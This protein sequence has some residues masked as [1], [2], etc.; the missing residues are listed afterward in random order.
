MLA[1]QEMFPGRMYYVAYPCTIQE[2]VEKYKQ[3]KLAK[4]EAARIRQDNITEKLKNSDKWT[5]DFNENIRK[6]ETKASK[7]A[8][9]KMIEDV[10]RYFGDTVKANDGKFKELLP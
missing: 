5:R 9:I 1:L 6:K 8:E 7:R 3:D 4:D 10:C 2:I